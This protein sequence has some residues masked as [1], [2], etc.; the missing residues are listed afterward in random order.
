MR[1]SHSIFIIFEGNEIHP[2]NMDGVPVPVVGDWLRFETYEAKGG[3]LFKFDIDNQDWIVKNVMRK[4]IVPATEVGY[5]SKN[6]LNYY[7]VT[8]EPK[9]SN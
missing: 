9:K 6:I 2:I 8:V 7:Y 3:E 5:L 4:V 1:D